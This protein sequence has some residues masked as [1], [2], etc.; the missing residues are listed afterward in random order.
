M[1]VVSGGQSRVVSP[2]PVAVDR[3]Q[4][5]LADDALAA[6]RLELDLPPASVRFYT[7]AVRS[8]LRS[9]I[10]GFATDAVVWIAADIA[11]WQVGP[12]VRHEA[13]HLAQER[14]GLPS[15]TPEAEAEAERYAAGDRRVVREMAAVH[16]AVA[17]VFAPSGV[18]ITRSAAAWR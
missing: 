10:R 14:H 11:P 9:A 5:R 1:I 18:T 3:R 17:A 16:A 4:Q 12:L 8:D 15:T 6:A 13:L 2:E 7:D